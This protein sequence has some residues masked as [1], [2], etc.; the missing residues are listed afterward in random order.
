[1]LFRIAVANPETEIIKNSL[2]PRSRTSGNEAGSMHE[3]VAFY[4]QHS[5]VTLE[6]ILYYIIYHTV[7]ISVY[8]IKYYM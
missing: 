1:M 2:S 6:L 5:S 3:I 8:N 7:D 4:C